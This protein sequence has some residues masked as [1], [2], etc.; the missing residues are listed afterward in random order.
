MPVFHRR[1]LYGL[2]F[3]L[4]GLAVGTYLNRYPGV[5]DAWFGEQAYWLQKDGIVR[6]NFFRGL[7]GWEKQLFVSHKLHLAIG[8]VCT[9]LIGYPL[10]GVQVVGVVFFLMLLGQLLYYLYRIEKQP[11]STYFLCLLVLVFLNRF[12]VRISFEYRP[13]LL[14]SVFGF[15]SFLCLDR[16]GPRRS[17][18]W[19]AAAGLLA[20][21]AALT[22]LNGVAYL[23]SG[24]LFLA[25]QRRWGLGVVFAA[26]GGAVGSLYF[27]DVVLAPDGFQT[28][29]YQFR[30][31]PATQNAFGWQTKLLVMLTYPRL[32]F[33]TPEHAALSVVFVYMVWHQRRYWVHIP[34]NLRQYFLTFLGV[35]WLLTKHPSGPYLVLF[36]PFMLL[37]IYQSYRQRPFWSR[38]L[39]GLLGVYALVGL[40]GLGE[41]V[42]TN[43]RREPLTTAYAAL[44]T[45]IGTRQTG[46]VP[47]TFFFNEYEQYR[48]LYC[49]NNAE[50]LVR[51]SAQLGTWAA[52]RGVEFIVFDYTFDTPPF[53]PKQ[54]EDNLPK[55]RLLFQ[56]D[57]FSVYTRR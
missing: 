57:R 17:N 34:A 1:W 19:A 13:D 56:N 55:Y 35:F 26:V 10:P 20:A 22:H 28:W 27:L 18:Y 33:Y 15:G 9:Y 29:L 11:F 40:Y 42:Y 21:C 48:Q 44:R 36:V 7:L 54:G 31:D 14:V 3:V 30:N 50:F 37:I 2:L 39:Q 47:I 24:V 6:S 46:L 4:I 8:A 45:P 23:V 53:A 52:A 32:F 49:H 5:D 38:S 43:A 41:L 16:I 12:L 25:W 51:E